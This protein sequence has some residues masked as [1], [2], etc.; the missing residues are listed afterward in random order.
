MEFLTK[1]DINECKKVLLSGELL[2]FPTETV[3]GLGAISSSEEAFNKLVETKKRP[4]NKPFTLMCSSLTQVQDIV[5]INNITQIIIDNFVP[6]PIT[7]I[8]KTKKDIPYYLDLGT[9]FVGIR[10]PDDDFVLKLIDAVGVPLLVP[11]ANIS[12]EPPAK[13]DK[14]VYNYFKDS[15]YIIEGACKSGVPSTIIKIDGNSIRMIREGTLTLK[16]IMEVIKWKRSH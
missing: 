14:E 15:V 3:Y 8:L 6:G 9:G 2:A 11:S 4:P 1:S 5:E 13:S 16:E 7:L 12:S 10:I